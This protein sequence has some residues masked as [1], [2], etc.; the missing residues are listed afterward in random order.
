LKNRRM[1]R[2]L[3]ICRPAHADGEIGSDDHLQSR[4]SNKIYAKKTQK[5]SKRN[6]SAKP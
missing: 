5:R 2:E 1:S 4:S 3:L 6:A